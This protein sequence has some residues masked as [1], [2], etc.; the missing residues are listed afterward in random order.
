MTLKEHSGPQLPPRKLKALVKSDS[1]TSV[2]RCAH[3]DSELDSGKP[4]WDQEDSPICLLDERSGVGPFWHSPQ[5]ARVA[6]VSAEVPARS[7]VSPAAMSPAIFRGWNVFG[8]SHVCGAHIPAGSRCWGWVLV[9]EGDLT[10]C[11]RL[12]RNPQAGG[13]WEAEAKFCYSSGWD[14][15]A[16]FRA[17]ADEKRVR[18]VWFCGFGV[19]CW[20][21]IP[22]CKLVRVE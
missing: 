10:H 2:C 12:L 5:S 8:C 17:K 19:L 22:V 9:K 3:P 21:V 1:C 16:Q 18:V 11:G 6:S 20:N 7:L 4:P 15:G 13:M 14:D